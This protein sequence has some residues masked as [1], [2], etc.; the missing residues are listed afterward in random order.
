MS[1]MV[2]F[3]FFLMWKC[4]VTLKLT[5]NVVLKGWHIQRR[6]A[7]MVS[8]ILCG[9]SWE[10]ELCMMP[11]FPALPPAPLRAIQ[12]LKTKLYANESLM[13]AQAVGFSQN[14]WVRES[15]IFSLL[16]WKGKGSDS[17]NYYTGCW[18]LHTICVLLDVDVAKVRWWRR[19]LQVWIHT[20]PVMLLLK[21]PQCTKL[22]H[23]LL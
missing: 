14:W 12:R 20:T 4:G 17:G 11:K 6:N 10:S 16:W 7:R 18:N 1:D 21:P 9:A 23:I 22:Q 19:H 3:F 8:D 5:S 13:Q 2:Y 15:R